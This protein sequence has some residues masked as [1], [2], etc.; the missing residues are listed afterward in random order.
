MSIKQRV[1]ICKIESI[2]ARCGNRDKPRKK[3]AERST[4]YADSAT[5]FDG[6]R[7][8]TDGVLQP[9]MEGRRQQA[10]MLCKTDVD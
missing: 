8:S 3:N 10:V 6:R 7:R 4:V 9:K 5:A 1:V 2:Y